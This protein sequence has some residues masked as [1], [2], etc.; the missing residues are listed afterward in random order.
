MIASARHRIVD[1]M[2]RSEKKPSGNMPRWAVEGKHL[3]ALLDRV[4][5]HFACNK[6]EPASFPANAARV[7][8]VAEHPNVDIARLAHLIERDP[9]MAAAVLSVAN[10][11]LYRRGVPIHSVRS[12]TTLLGLR[13]VASVAV[14]VACRALFDVEVRVQHALYPNWWSRL[15]HSSMTEAFASSF[16]AIE[17]RKGTSDTVFLAGM[18]N[19]IGKAL[20]LRSLSALIVNGDVPGVPTDEVIDTVL[21][22]T[23][24]E[25]GV[26]AQRGWNLPES[27]IRV[28]EHQCD[29]QVPTGPE[30]LDTH[31]IRVVSGLNDLRM[32]SFE[33]ATMQRSLTNSARAL[34]FS[35]E[36]LVTI[37][38]QVSDYA[39][40]VS[41]LFSTTDGANETGYLEWVAA[42]LHVD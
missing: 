37:A 4:R 23:Y 20:A 22:R 42:C 29:E 1:P 21:Q 5:V 14:G 16:L 31:V 13:Q 34:G 9:A 7:M 6:P 39:A 3:D 38:R 35:R 40:Q 10:S 41:A 33:D 25:F 2:R 8:D 30:W 32:G 11:A 26:Q 15:Y 27:L 28:C 19:D 17:R 24:V 18:F 36:D 12:A